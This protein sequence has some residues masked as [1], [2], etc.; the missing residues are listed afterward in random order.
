MMKKL[1]QLPNNNREKNS[2]FILQ[3]F[4]FQSNIRALESIDNGFMHM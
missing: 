4:E 1:S 3:D 2:V